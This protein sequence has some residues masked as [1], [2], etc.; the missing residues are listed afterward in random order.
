MPLERRLDPEMFFR[1]NRSQMINLHAIEAIDV[2]VDWSLCAHMR[3]GMRVEISRRQS[4]RLKDVAG[5]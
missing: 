3:G 1:A 4:K 5:L 2:E